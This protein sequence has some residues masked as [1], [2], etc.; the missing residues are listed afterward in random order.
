[1]LIHEATYEQCKC[2][3]DRK[4]LRHEVYGCDVCRKA[5]DVNKP[6]IDSHA[7]TVFGEDN[8]T[9]QFCSVKCF[10]KWLKAFKPAKDYRFIDLPLFSGTALLRQL[11][12]TLK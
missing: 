4:R 10:A 9:Y 3:R 1:M 2:C 11:Q 7:A 6:D 5:I 8:K 12:K